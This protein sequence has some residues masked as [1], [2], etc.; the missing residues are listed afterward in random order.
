[1][2]EDGAREVDPALDGLAAG[3]VRRF[4]QKANGILLEEVGGHP[5]A[6]GV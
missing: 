6:G 2:V 3:C 1:M 5:G 4:G